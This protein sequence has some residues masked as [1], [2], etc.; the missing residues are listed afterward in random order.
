VGDSDHVPV[1]VLKADVVTVDP[2]TTG[3]TEFAG[4]R[5]WATTAEV[6]TV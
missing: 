4:G 1:V 2:V 3:A 6:L 5:N